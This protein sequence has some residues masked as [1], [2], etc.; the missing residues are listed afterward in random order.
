MYSN[1]FRTANAINQDS[2]VPLY[3]QLQ[4]ILLHQIE[5]GEFNPGDPFPSE[6]ELEEKYGVSR[7]TVRR[8]LSELTV[9]GYLSRRAGRR[10]WVI[11]Q[12]L[13]TISGKLGGIF[14]DLAAQGFQVQSQILELDRRVAPRK[15][16]N[17]LQVS[18]RSEV[19][20]F[21]RLLSVDREPIGLTHFFLKANKPIILT[22]D[23]LERGSVFPT[24]E[25]KY[26][27][28]LRRARQTIEAATPLDEECKLLGIPS[29][30]PVLLFESI[31]CYENGAPASFGKTIYR[32]DRYRHYV[33]ATR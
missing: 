12:K 7:I 16:V 32:G 8:A 33:E 28:K 20:Y 11:S 5:S 1:S 19:T 18:E 25:K 4:Q 14:E 3:Y 6:N 31:S 13:Q 30:V 23:E 9:R 24:L 29:S 21:K 26:G 27:I 22:R 15:V 2:P 17:I 10:T